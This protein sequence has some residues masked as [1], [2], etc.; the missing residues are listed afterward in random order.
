MKARALADVLVVGINSDHSVQRL[1]G[2]DRPLTRLQDRLEILAA[3]ECVDFV[4]YFSESTPERLITML[5]P[6]I[7]VKGGDYRR[8]EVVGGDFVEER[9]GKVVILPLIPGRSTR[10]LVEKIRSRG[11]S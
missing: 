8:E 7:L 4:T 10:N 11:R 6:D 1:K 2:K 5:K 3:L 9:G